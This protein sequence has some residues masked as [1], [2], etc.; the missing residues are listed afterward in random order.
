MIRQHKASSGSGTS[1]VKKSFTKLTSDPVCRYKN[2]VCHQPVLD[3]YDYCLKHILE[4]KSA[5][6]KPCGYAY[7]NNNKRCLIPALKS[8]KSDIGYCS[9][10]TW[11]TQIKSQRSTSKHV[12]PTTPEFLLSG[13]SHYVKPVRNVK[14]EEGEEVKSSSRIRAI[15]P[16]VETDVTKA[17]QTKTNVL[18]CDSESDSDVEPATLDNIWKGANEDSSDAESIDSQADDPLKHAGYYTSEEAVNVTRSKLMRLQVLYQRQFERLTY[19]LKEKRR[20]Y[21]HSLRKEKE[22]LSSIYDQAKTSAKEQKLYEK[23]KALNRYH[24]RSN[25]ESLAYL[26]SIE[27]RARD[28]SGNNYKPHG[29]SQ[30]CAFTEGGD[31]NQCLFKACGCAKADTSC[32]VPITGLCAGDTCILHIR[33]PVLPHLNYP[34]GEVKIENED[35]RIHEDSDEVDASATESA[36]STDNRD[37]PENS[38]IHNE[39]NVKKEDDSNFSEQVIEETVVDDVSENVIECST[40]KDPLNGESETMEVD[41]PPL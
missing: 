4:D 39:D 17:F 40:S 3:K 25:C 14:S 33:L 32:Q 8:E 21:L 28:I 36:F 29:H 19:L 24:K 34:D 10:H 37:S 11:K 41:E 15:D 22:T 18:E 23:L 9:L 30:R 26:A 38:I 2:R 6:Y 13:L 31:S 5:P 16:F 27:K 12:P 20:H 35:K 7:P 1:T